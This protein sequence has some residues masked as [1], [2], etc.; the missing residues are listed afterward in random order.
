M[1]SGCAKVYHAV[2]YNPVSLAMHDHVK[3]YYHSDKTG[4]IIAKERCYIP[5]EPPC[6]GYEPTCWTRWPADCPKCPID[7]ECEQ[8]VTIQDQV[9]GGAHESVIVD[10]TT[11]NESATPVEA[12]PEAGAGPEDLLAPSDSVE[13]EYEEGATLAPIISPEDL[14]NYQSTAL[15]VKKETLDPQLDPQ[16]LAGSTVGSVDVAEQAIRPLEQPRSIAEPTPHMDEQLTQPDTQVP[17]P[18]APTDRRSSRRRRT[19]ADAKPSATPERAGEVEGHSTDFDMLATTQPKL[20]VKRETIATADKIPSFPIK[21]KTGSVLASKTS[22]TESASQISH[23]PKTKVTT[24]SF[25]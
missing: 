4:R 5:E 13:P 1:N 17:E 22:H 7:C 12:E 16:W 2:H 8:E 23:R 14:P 11:A 6:Y 15:P 25:R 24:V 10:E 19:V 3:N 9:I 18:S 21:V 20:N